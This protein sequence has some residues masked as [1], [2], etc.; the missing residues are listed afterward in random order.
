MH[1]RLSTLILALS[2]VPTNPLNAAVRNVPATYA[3]IQAA[4]NAAAD[5]DEVVISPGTYVENINLGGKNIKVRSSDPTSATI[6]SATIID[7]NQAG[8]VIN[9]AGSESLACII[10]GLTIRNGKALQGGGISGHSAHATIRYNNIVQN[11]A[12]GDH[13]SGGGVA[14]INGV[15]HDCLI[16]TNTASSRGGG[17]YGCDTRIYNNIIEYN[18]VV[19]GSYQSQNIGGGIDGCRTVKCNIIRHNN[20][21]F[22]GGASYNFYV[23]D[24]IIHHNSAVSGAGVHA[25]FSFL[26][27]N[28]IAHNTASGEAGGFLESDNY[29]WVVNNILWGNTAPSMPQTN[30][31][32]PRFY[33]CIEGWSGGGLGTINSDPLFVNPAAEDFRLQAV[34]P[35]RDTG[36]TWY[37]WASPFCDALKNC[38]VAGSAIDM[39]AVEYGATLD[40]DSDLLADTAEAGNS[41]NASVA[42]T[43]GDGLI[44]GLEILRGTPPNISQPAPGISIASGQSVQRALFLAYPNETITLAPGTYT[45][46]LFSLSKD[47]TVKSQNPS[48]SAIV[49]STILDG[50]SRQSVI[51]QTSH[52]NTTVYFK[53]LTIQNGLAAIGGGIR[54]NASVYVEDCVIRNNVATNQGGG[55][56]A[57]NSLFAR[58]IIENNTAPTAAGL[59]YGS[60]NRTIIRNNVATGTGGG[61]NYGFLF[62]S[63]LYDNQANVGGGSANTSAYFC[64]FYN[65]TAAS[66]GGG[67]DGASDMINSIAWNNSA[68]AGAQINGVSNVE[69]SCIQNGAGG[70][71]ANISADPRFVQASS[72]DFRLKS[73]SPCV[74][75]ARHSGYL[76]GAVDFLGNPRPVNLPGITGGDGSAYDMGAF[77]LQALPSAVCAEWQLYM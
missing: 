16:S 27:G 57:L 20:A 34:S 5:G 39:G 3:T 41:C 21:V 74:D 6:R 17:I 4:I 37:E 29:A 66:S 64:V 10:E 62:N 9:L 75:T 30:T 38:R 72:R 69:Y 43:D 53:G 35:C 24:N 73:D 77:E 33:C 7:G 28:T 13:A 47:F 45:E 8:P 18:S 76:D 26:G 50:A 61:I 15:V 49:T 1:I 59:A 12:E 63:I 19:S 2:L 67:M 11:A 52:F 22:G 32:V 55:G 14:A 54:C 58:C 48:S 71:I 46:N 42:D 31:P 60:A 56:E 68:P 51:Y 23:L 36:S 70:G 65:N 44:D 25:V 40:S